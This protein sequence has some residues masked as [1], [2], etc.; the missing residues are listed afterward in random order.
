MNFNQAISTPGAFAMD[1]DIT[2]YESKLNDYFLAN[3]LMTFKREVILL[4][5]VSE[6]I[7]KV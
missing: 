4:S 1:I 3:T 6:E 2:I 7:Y 5:L